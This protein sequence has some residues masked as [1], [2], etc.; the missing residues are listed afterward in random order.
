MS[1]HLALKFGLAFADLYSHE[2]AVRIDRAF[3]DYLGA[4]DVSLLDRLAR[5]RQSPEA[6]TRKDQSQLIIDLAPYVEDFIGELFGIQRAVAELQARHN[7]LAPI[8]S[9]LR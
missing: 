8:Y 7:S 5:A 9:T 2:G 1:D 4:S 3:Q 6:L